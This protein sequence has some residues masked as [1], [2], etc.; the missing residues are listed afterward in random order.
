MDQARSQL[1]KWLGGKITGAKDL[2]ISEITEPTTSGFSNETLLFSIDYTR[3][4]EAQHEELV[5]RVQPTGYQVFP[6]YDMSIQFRAMDLPWP[7]RRSRSTRPLARER[8]YGCPWSTLLSHGPRRGTCPHR[9]P[10]IPRRRLG[11]GNL[12]RGETKD[13]AGRL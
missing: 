2:E 1:V 5:T 12:A 6:S 13:L 8:G 4:G 9:Q 10:A 3:N 7:N 11:D